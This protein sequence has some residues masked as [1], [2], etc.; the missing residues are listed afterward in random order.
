MKRINRAAVT[1][2]VALSLTLA[3]CGTKG[4]ES[5]AAE[6]GAGGLKTD[7]GITDDTIT[8]GN[9]TDTSGVFKDIGIAISNGIQIWADDVNEDGGICGRQVKIDLKD[10]GYQADKAVPLYAAMNDDVAG[11][12]QVLGSPII[13][14][15]K[16]QL[17]S[18]KM[19]TIPATQAATNLAIPGV[20]MI[21]PSYDIEMINVLA[22]AQEKGL[23]ADGQK[24]GHIYIEGEYGESGLNGS[25]YYAELHDQTVVPINVSPS[26]N[27]MAAAVTKLKG[28]GVS[29]VLLTT[30]AAQLSSTA[31]QMAAQGMGN[32]PI[33]GNNPTWSPTLPST[34][35]VSALGNY[36]RSVGIAPWGT[37]TPLIN[38]IE[39]TYLAE[40]TEPPEDHINTGYAFGLVSQAVLEQGC[41][42]KDMTR[43]G[44]VEAATK[45]DN[46]DTGGITAP[47][48]FSKQGVPST[49]KTFIEQMDPN[50]P[51]GLKIVDQ[52]SASGEAK[53]YKSPLL[54]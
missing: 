21:G 16:S 33:L 18:D 41:K 40:Y 54:K 51:G 13:A 22:Y 49:R 15:L 11:M 14:A 35:A 43:A 47:L 19:F 24:L 27:D 20:L 9:L 28:A 6:T 46:V 32:M 29:A 36:Y 2:T 45:V 53:D 4:G 10:T 12:V 1:G 26:T 42:D 17:V 44:L 3:A 31:T 48:D 8:L 25:K 5:G 23:I 50:V 38:S 37:D 7:Y 30:T 39:E 52:L 34:P